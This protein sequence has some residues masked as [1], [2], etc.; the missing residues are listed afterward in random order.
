MVDMHRHLPQVG[1]PPLEQDW[2][3][4]FATSDTS[5]WNRMTEAPH[6]QL[7]RHGYGI[8]PQSISHERL[9]E[10][11]MITNLA[12]ALDTALGNNPL[13]YVGEIGLDVRF[14]NDI[15]SETQFSLAYE[16]MQIAKRRGRP[17][18][19]HHIGPMP[20][21]L[22]LLEEVQPSTPTII[23]GYV[24][25]VESARRLADLGATISLGPTVWTHKTKLSEH[26]AK[27][28]VPFLLETDYPFVSASLH[29]AYG[30]DTLCSTH[31][32]RISEL[33]GRNI[34]EIEEQVYGQATLFTHW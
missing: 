19:I 32:H 24:K 34:E 4:W 33:M 8:L 20:R 22:R 7:Y 27:L 29:D 15:S 3:I 2:I 26:L 12:S 14:E 1:E 18:V 6:N 9:V 25:S 31:L 11:D 23:H 21:L 30:Y 5:E 10:P 13:G 16:L 28:D 17:T